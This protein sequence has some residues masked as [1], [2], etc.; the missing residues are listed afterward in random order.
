MIKYVTLTDGIHNLNL[1]STHH[2]PSGKNSGLLSGSYW[3]PR[4]KNYWSLRFEPWTRIRSKECSTTKPL[5]SGP[6]FNPTRENYL[7]FFRY[8]VFSHAGSTTAY[9]FPEFLGLIVSFPRQLFHDSFLLPASRSSPAF[10]IIPFSRQLHQ[11]NNKSIE[12]ESHCAA[13]ESNNISRSSCY[14]PSSTPAPLHARTPCLHLLRTLPRLTS[15]LRRQQG[16]REVYI[17][18]PAPT[19][20]SLA[21][22]NNFL[23]SANN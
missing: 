7:L 6:Q 19:H 17:N 23:L 9:F 4:K 10:T 1:S 12:I 16:Q 5:L 2:Y 21:T 3:R 20:T 15:G 13:S 22:L 18:S 14:T 8:Y 11:S